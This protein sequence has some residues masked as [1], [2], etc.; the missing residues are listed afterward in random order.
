M[1][2]FNPIKQ[3]RNNLLK[4]LSNKRSAFDLGIGEQTIIGISYEDILQNL[5]CSLD[6]LHLI[7]SELFENKEIKYY[8]V[9]G[10]EG[11]CCTLKGVVAFSNN[12]Y[13]NDAIDPYIL[14]A[15]NISTI[16]VPILSLII[17]IIALTQ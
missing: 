15:K 9:N 13:K 2:T 1:I 11:L 4:L 3:K 17:T 7:T 8:N 10:I 12:K 6:E 14:R 16:L 5:N